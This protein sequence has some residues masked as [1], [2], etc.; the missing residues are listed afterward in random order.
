MKRLI[1]VLVLAFSFAVFAQGSAAPAPAG[2]K[3][4]A[5][6]GEKK[7]KAK[8]SGKKS[9]KKGDETKPETAK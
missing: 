7:Q 4:A 6:K 2:D 3:P 5:E 8:K 9:E 1:S